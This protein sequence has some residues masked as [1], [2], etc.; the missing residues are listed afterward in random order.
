MTKRREGK[1]LKEIND[2]IENELKVN[3]KNIDREKLRIT[4]LDFGI[5]YKQLECRL[6]PEYTQSFLYKAFQWLD[7]KVET[8]DMV[9][10]ITTPPEKFQYKP[11]LKQL[12]LPI[13][14]AIHLT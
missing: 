6:T 10:K 14:L 1:S 5:H 7:A 3:Q 4:A 11:E 8:Y 2:K 13:E 12:Q 9:F